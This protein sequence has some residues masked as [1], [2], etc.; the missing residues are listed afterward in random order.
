MI[1]FRLPLYSRTV[2]EASPY[3]P[4]FNGGSYGGALVP[5]FETHQVYTAYGIRKDRRGRRSL[6]GVWNSLRVVEGADPYTAYKNRWRHV[7]ALAK[8]MKMQLD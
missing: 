3:K 2:L 6:H 4:S 7:N 5:P 1:A 8:N